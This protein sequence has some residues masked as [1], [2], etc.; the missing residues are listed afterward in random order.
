MDEHFKSS[1]F[2]GKK[3]IVSPKTSS[4][5]A[6]VNGTDGRQ[7]LASEFDPRRPPD[8]PSETRRR[9]EQFIY[10]KHNINTAVE[11][12]PTP[13]FDV[14]FIAYRR[15]RRPILPHFI[16]PPGR[17]CTCWFAEALPPSWFCLR[18]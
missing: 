3:F 5:C 2:L 14:S 16:E 13:T 18:A 6:A 9:R 17:T 15:R 12:D 4:Q 7:L 11:I 1:T 10:Y 8:R